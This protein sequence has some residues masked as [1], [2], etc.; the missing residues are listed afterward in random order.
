[1]KNKTQLKLI[2]FCDHAL[3]DNNNKLSVIGIFDQVNV[4]KFPGG[5]PRAFFVATIKTEPNKKYTFS[6]K[7]DLKNET[8]F[9]A[10][11]MEGRVGD[12][13]Y[14]NIILDLK[15]IAFP[16]PGVYQFFLS[17][18]EEKIGSVEL[19]VGEGKHYEQKLPN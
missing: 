12:S 16:K 6:V 5:L 4:N 10:I 3:I 17:Q 15:G 2:T 9:P 1:M 19:K 14:H 8:V 7:G 13:G 11:N 18:D